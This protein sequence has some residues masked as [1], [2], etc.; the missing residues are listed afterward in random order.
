[1]PER[2]PTIELTLPQL[3][4]YIDAAFDEAERWARFKEIILKGEDNAKDNAT[5]L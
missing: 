5:T 4:A 2:A 3:I 1:M